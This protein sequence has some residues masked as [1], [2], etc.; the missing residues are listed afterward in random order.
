MLS[1]LSHRLALCWLPYRTPTLFITQVGYNPQIYLLPLLQ[2]RKTPT[3]QKRGQSDTDNKEPL[4]PVTINRSLRTME[5][6][7]IL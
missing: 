1:V 3:P 2:V 6:Y 7:A 5:D 4:H